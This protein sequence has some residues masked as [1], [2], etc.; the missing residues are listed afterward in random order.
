[1]THLRLSL[2]NGE[3][4]M[5]KTFNTMLNECKDYLEMPRLNAEEVEELQKRLFREEYLEYT[6][7]SSSFSLMGNRFDGDIIGMMDGLVDMLYVSAGTM[8]YGDYTGDI[9][10]FNKLADEMLAVTNKVADFNKLSYIFGGYVQF[11][12][13]LQLCF[14]EVQASNMSKLGLDVFG[15]TIYGGDPWTSKYAVEVADVAF[16]NGKLLK[17][18]TTYFPP[19]LEAIVLEHKTDNHLLPDWIYKNKGE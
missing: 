8:Y 14:E 7:Y 18:A 5:V 3:Y 15:S 2:Q 17:T 10:R 1:M 9:N 6:S 13:V 12:H 11:K 4:D 16:Q 19:K